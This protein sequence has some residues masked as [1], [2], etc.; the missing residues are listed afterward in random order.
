MMEM[1]LFRILAL[2][3]FLELTAL[4]CV[5]DQKTDLVETA[6]K[7]KI[8]LN[9]NQTITIDGQP[10][11]FLYY[12][13]SGVASA[14]PLVILLHG[15]TVSIDAMAGR[16]SAAAP[17]KVWMEIADRDKF[18]VVYAQGLV[19]SDGEYGWNDCRADNTEVPTSDDVKFIN[20]LIRSPLYPVDA[21][22]VYVVG[23][24]N[25]GMM[26][27][28]MALDSPGTVAAIGAVIA[29]MPVNSEC[30]TPTQPTSILFMGGT[31]DSLV[32]YAAGVV[33]GTA[34]KGLIKSVADS[35]QYWK[36]L[37]GTGTTASS[38]TNFP[39]IDTSDSSTVSLNTYTGG[40]NTTSVY[41]Y[42]VSGGGHLEPS[43][44][45]RYSA[46]TEAVLG[47]QNNDVEMAEMIWTFLKDK[48]K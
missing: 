5:S 26:A 43:V 38:T 46:I 18:V 17:Y 28:R 41:E 44:K 47:K 12:I 40:T 4:S 36:T 21:R 16:T 25:G 37:N 39:D 27:L 45:E 13:P 35:V 31:A 6:S 48:K 24:S 8:G 34:T 22:R 9:A 23:S 32:P 11:K 7:Y 1:T 14:V 30:A 33:G 42:T 20:T 29:S 2:L 15:H 19:G 3:V 10:R